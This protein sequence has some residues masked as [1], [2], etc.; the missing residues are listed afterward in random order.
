[1]QALISLCL[2]GKAKT[3]AVRKLGAVSDGALDSA[4]LWPL[5]DLLHSIKTRWAS[6]TIPAG[7][8]P[9]GAWALWVV[10]RFPAGRLS[11]PGADLLSRSLTL[12]QP[13]AL[14]AGH[15]HDDATKDKREMGNTTMAEME[16]RTKC[17]PR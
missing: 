11:L 3:F 8:H 13:S 14:L 2:S 12:L 9:S 15:C 4:R 7:R 6:W 10:G 1:M 16:E 5:A 17:R